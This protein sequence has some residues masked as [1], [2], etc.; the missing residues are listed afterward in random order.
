VEK[1]RFFYYLAWRVK[2][3]VVRLAVRGNGL[4]CRVVRRQRVPVFERHRLPAPSSDVTYGGERSWK[5]AD[6]C[7]FGVAVIQKCFEACG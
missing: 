6:F 2:K 4:S 1:G 3:N 7:V 5:S